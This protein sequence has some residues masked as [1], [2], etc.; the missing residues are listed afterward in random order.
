MNF[1]ARRSRRSKSTAMHL[2]AEVLI[3]EPR[4]L[5]AGN[6]TLTYSEYGVVEIRGDGQ[7]NSVRLFA[8]QYHY[9]AQGIGT[10][11]NGLDVPVALDDFFHPGYVNPNFHIDLGEGNDSLQ[12]DAGGSFTI[13]GSAGNDTTIVRAAILGV[14]DYGVGNDSGNDT[15]LL[16]GV[17]GL[18]QAR[19]DLGAGNDKLSIRDVNSMFGV[20]IVGNTGN[21]ETRIQNLSTLDDFSYGSGGT[22]TGNDVLSISQCSLRTAHLNLGGGNDRINI[23]NTLFQTAV[24]RID[25]G[26]G[27]DTFRSTAWMGEQIIVDAGAGADLLKI[28]LQAKR[29]DLL[30]GDGNDSLQIQNLKTVEW[31]TIRAGAGDDKITLWKCDL[32]SSL[33]ITGA[34]GRDTLSM[35]MD[36]VGSPQVLVSGIEIRRSRP[37]G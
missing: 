11:I 10:T 3:P 1:F 26:D 29:L 20:T 6:V 34:E 19:I 18:N 27:N 28:D 17:R 31:S 22:D 5:P 15:L 37:V 9:Y 33:E 32:G 13:A 35:A 16:E 8:D 7:D 14:F 25:L 4:V 23:D 2:A 30:G 12:V 21:D 36:L 24:S